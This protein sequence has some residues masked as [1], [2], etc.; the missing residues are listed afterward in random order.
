VSYPDA[1]Q[2][3]SLVRVDYVT[4][5][6]GGTYVAYSVPDPLR[7]GMNWELRL[8]D[9]HGTEYMGVQGGSTYL[10]TLQLL[11]PWRPTVHGYARFPALPPTARTAVVRFAR[12]GHGTPGTEM[13]RV[14]LHLQGLTRVRIVH[15]RGT[16]TVH[17]ITLSAS[18]LRNGPADASL[19][20][21]IAAP[22]RLPVSGDG[23]STLAGRDGRP[24]VLTGLSGHCM[25]ELDRSV[26]CT[27][28]V[29]FAPQPRGS[30]IVL[31]LPSLWVYWP[32]RTTRLAGPWRLTLTMP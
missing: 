15:P 30:R 20:Y 24:I 17:G 19:T 27:S 28:G 5:D 6:S 26:R 1:R 29:S 10:S 14:A 9:E 2:P 32:P 7:S 31:T 8:F 21:H 12:F 22:A 13:V 25:G 18:T 4:V 23:P 16:S 11:V 3:A